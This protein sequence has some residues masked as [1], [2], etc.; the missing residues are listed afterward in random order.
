M[1]WGRAKSYDCVRDPG[2]RI[3]RYTDGRLLP[4]FDK[5]LGQGCDLLL[6]EGLSAL[7]RHIDI[8]DREDLPLHHPCYST[9]K[10]CGPKLRRHWLACIGTCH[11]GRRSLTGPT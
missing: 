10:S 8:L 7:H 9:L 5:A 1:K 11:P 4:L 2:T 6:I 3:F